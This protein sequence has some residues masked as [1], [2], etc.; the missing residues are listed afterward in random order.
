M[1]D[2]SDRVQLNQVYCEKILKYQR[3]EKIFLIIVFAIICGICFCFEKF[4]FFES[5]VFFAIGIAF[6]LSDAV[7]YHY[8]LNHSKIYLEIDTIQAV[9]KGW[10]CKNGGS[11]YRV[12]YAHFSNNGKYKIRKSLTLSGLKINVNQDIANINRDVLNHLE[13]GYR[14]YLLIAERKNK[15]KILQIFSLASFGIETDAFEEQD[16]R[17][18]VR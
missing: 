15:K 3:N 16:G 6:L 8:K 10:F 4:K 13:E 11:Y 2:R 7:L 1:K 17:Y 9:K 14:F 5:V 12:F 18:I